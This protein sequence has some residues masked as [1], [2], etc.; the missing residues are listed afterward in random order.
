MQVID[1]LDAYSSLCDKRNTFVV[2]SIKRDLEHAIDG[3]N[4]PDTFDL[5]GNTTELR[6]TRVNDDYLDILL[7]PMR[8]ID[9]L[10]KLNL[11]YNN[12][13]DQGATNLAH[14]LKDDK[15]LV[16]INL[17]ANEIKS[18]GGVA[19]A[20]ALQINLTLTELDIGDNGIGDFAGLEFAGTLQ[21]VNTAI[22]RLHIDGCDLRATSFI[23]LFTVLQNNNTCSFLNISNNLCHSASLTQTVQNDIMIHMSKML[24]LN[25]TISRL[26][27]KKFGITDWAMVDT[28]AN[29]IMNNSTLVILD[30][31]RWVSYSSAYGI[32]QSTAKDR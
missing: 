25:H 21:Q 18:Q 32:Q 16:W 9:F 17:R 11:S 26:G 15:Y 12:I 13:G 3:G 7:T 4:L 2:S 1:Y 28:F 29:T 23:S 8:G 24:R 30:L 22:H 20:K 19:L 14:F 10:R 31:C 27:L 6:Y 5:S